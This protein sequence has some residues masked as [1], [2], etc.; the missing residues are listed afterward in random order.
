MNRK[1]R[2][3]NCVTTAQ[4]IP[5]KAQPARFQFLI[6][7]VKLHVA[8]H[9]RQGPSLRYAF[10]RWAYQPF[11]HYARFQKAPGQVKGRRIIDSL[12][13]NGN[14]SVMIQRAEVLLNVQINHPFTPGVQI[15][16]RL[17]I[18]V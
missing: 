7:L 9:R 18:A 10:V 6:Q 14:Q 8:Q 1:N 12:P 3:P 5:H 16:K 11:F 4:A 13:E 17:P 15:F 2:S